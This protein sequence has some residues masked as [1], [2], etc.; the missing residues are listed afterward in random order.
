MTVAIGLLFLLTA[1][2]KSLKGDQPAEDTTY[3][4]P[5]PEATLLAFREG[6][7]IENKLQA[8]TAARRALGYM[9]FVAVGTPT[10]LFVGEMSPGEAYRRLKMPD[11]TSL[12]SPQMDSMVWLTLFEGD[13]QV[14]PPG[15]QP[16][17]IVHGCAFV[18]I[19]AD[20]SPSVQMGII[21][22]ATV[23]GLIASPTP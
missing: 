3:L 19:N 20:G 6:K 4:T 22:C 16:L 14:T 7:P 15:E 11:S 18:I 13:F 17:P 12:I 2:A 5:I 21:D 9:H 1:C 8:A 23:K 10:V